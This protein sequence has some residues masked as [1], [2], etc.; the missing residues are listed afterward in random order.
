MALMN[1]DEQLCLKEE[2]SDI[3]WGGQSEDTVILITFI[4]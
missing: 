2:L 3:F 4:L 1:P